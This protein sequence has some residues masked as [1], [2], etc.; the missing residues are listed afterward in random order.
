MGE[1]EFDPYE[2]EAPF[3]YECIGCGT[4]V[5]ADHQPETCPDCGAQMRDLSVSHE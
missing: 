4:R 3:V 5:E 1:Q 2:R